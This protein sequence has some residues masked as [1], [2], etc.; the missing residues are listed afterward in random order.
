MI[1]VPP[2]EE[3]AADPRDAL[4][5]EQ[6]QVIAAQAERIAAL[7]ALVGDLRERLAAA[8]RAGS[9]NSGNSSMPPSWDDLP[10]R[11]LPIW[12]P[13]TV[14]GMDI[15]GF[16]LLLERSAG[17]T[18]GPR[19]RIRWLEHRL[20]QLSR[21][22]IVDFQVHLDTARRPIDTYAMWGAASLITD[23]LLCSGDGFWYF[24]PWLIG[25]GS[26]GTSSPPATQTTSLTSLRS[27]RWPADGQAS[28]PMRSGRNGKNSTTSPAA[29]TTR[30][31]ARK[32]ASMT[33][34][35][36]VVISAALPL[37]PPTPSGTST[38]SPKSS[39]ACHDSPAC[40]H[41]SDTSRL[42]RLTGQEQRFIKQVGASADPER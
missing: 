27:A 41:A 32:T 42:E 21:T 24:Q 1:G 2:P 6:A 30:S 33:R 31:P 38:T 20:S 18:T 10:R 23:G 25:Q 36:H 14:T 3:P 29:S 11:K 4:I 7:E 28:G 9:R 8:E 39:G 5:R 22:D 34:W 37:P 16:W 19:Q 13:F 40:S 26:A 12:P 35:P 17:E 15:D